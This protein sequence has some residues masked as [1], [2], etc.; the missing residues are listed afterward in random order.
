VGNIRVSHDGV[1]FQIWAD[2]ITQGVNRSEHAS[3]PPSGEGDV[4]YVNGNHELCFRAKDGT[5]TVL[6]TGASEFRT[7]L[8]LA[9][10]TLRCKTD[11]CD[12]CAKT[13]TF[14]QEYLQKTVLEASK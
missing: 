9:L 1:Y 14:I 10:H 5:T 2:Q 8:I 12:E 13:E 4:L 6:T 7:L 3:P 11:A